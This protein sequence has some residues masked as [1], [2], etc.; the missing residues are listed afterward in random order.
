MNW[1]PIETA[2]AKPV[3]DFPHQNLLLWVVGAGDDRK[4][5]C[6]LGVAY[7]YPDG[8]KHPIANGYGGS[9]KITHWAE[10]P[11]SPYL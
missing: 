6:A 2:P 10:L 5:C 3:D 1:Q 7:L 9:W 8:S 11:E 4:G